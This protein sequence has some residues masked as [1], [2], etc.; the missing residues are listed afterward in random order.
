MNVD[1]GTFE[2]IEADCDEMRRTMLQLLRAILDATAVAADR[3][4][5]L[6][7]QRGRHARPK[8]TIVW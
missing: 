3:M 2:A 6:E 7:H 8:L 4:G 5:A 1:T